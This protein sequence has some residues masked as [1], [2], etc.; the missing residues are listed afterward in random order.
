MNFGIDLMAGKVAGVRPLP[1]A[2]AV[3]S[4]LP[5]INTATLEKNI[6]ADVAS[7]TDVSNNPRARIARTVGLVIGSPE[8]Q[9]R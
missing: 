1:R 7:N 4:L 6:A 3:T 2:V 5:G 9:K 8:F